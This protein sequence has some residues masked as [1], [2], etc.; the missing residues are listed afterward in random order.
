M[1]N[2]KKKHLE[3]IYDGY[4]L[5]DEKREGIARWETRQALL[6]Q[7]LPSLFTRYR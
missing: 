4:D 7:R 6:S 5:F 2:H 3:E 1:P